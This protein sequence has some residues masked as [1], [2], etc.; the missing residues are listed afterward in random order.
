MTERTLEL[1]PPAGERFTRMSTAGCEPE[2]LYLDLDGDGVPDAVRVTTSEVLHATRDGRGNVVHV[3]SELV[4]GIGD[5][6]RARS[7]MPSS[8]VEIQP[9]I[10]AT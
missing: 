5:D 10:D 2:V 3:T 9:F 1:V 6:G 8:R 4:E 7:T